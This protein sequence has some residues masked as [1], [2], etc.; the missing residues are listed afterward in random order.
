MQIALHM[1]VLQLFNN[2]IWLGSQ[3]T[4]ELKLISVFKSDVSSATK[5]KW[6]LVKISRE[7]FI[8]KRNKRGPR[9]LPC[10][11]PLVGLYSLYCQHKLN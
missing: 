8:Y 5:V 3:P 10:A 4:I 7:L 6:Q 1:Y 2:K 9:I 11:T